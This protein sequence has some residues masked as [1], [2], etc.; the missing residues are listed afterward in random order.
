MDVLADR[1]FV[2]LTRATASIV[3]TNGDGLLIGLVVENRR[4]QNK[5][6]SVFDGTLARCEASALIEFAGERFRSGTE[7][8]CVLS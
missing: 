8:E 5:V 6:R 2:D 3:P 7:A 4:D 1:R